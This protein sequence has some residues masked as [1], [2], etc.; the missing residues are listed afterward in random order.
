MG[1]G[2]GR[3][4][5]DRAEALLRRLGW[6]DAFAPVGAGWWPRFRVVLVAYGVVLPVLVLDAALGGGREPVRLVA[7]TTVGV[8]AWTALCFWLGVRWRS[9]RERR[10]TGT[11]AAG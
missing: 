1:R 8:L 5:D 6:A 11:G 10:R 7:A 9:R 3:G 2:L 4:L